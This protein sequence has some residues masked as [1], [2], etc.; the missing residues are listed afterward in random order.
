MERREGVD[1]V[2][3]GNDFSAE[4]TADACERGRLITGDVSVGASV[5]KRGSQSEVLTVQ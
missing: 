1:V 5:V 2:V 3:N 4:L